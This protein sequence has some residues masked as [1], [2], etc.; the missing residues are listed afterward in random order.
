MRIQHL[1][2]AVALVSLT[3]SCASLSTLPQPTKPTSWLYNS[4]TFEIAPVNSA[5]PSPE[6]LEFFRKRLH[7]N[8]LCHR[9]RVNF[10]IRRYTQGLP[11]GFPWS[12]GSLLTYEQ[13]RR[14]IHDDSP[15][16]SDL[17]VFV[18]YI[19]GLFRQGRELRH[20]G[21]LQYSHTAFAIFKSGARD[22]EG[23]VLL[24]EFGH[25]IGLVKDEDAP[26]HDG[27]NSHHCAIQTCAMY[28]SSPMDKADFD[29]Y[30]KRA[31]R[32]MIRTRHEEKL[33]AQ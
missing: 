6:A 31:I 5:N 25:L 2:L 16:D 26:N 22:R 33:D 27:I 9:D 30:C 4:I 8:R 29:L 20:L 17:K 15:Y 3:I 32:V 23:A 7:E 13:M 21:G 28:H 12:T 24:H 11:K 18:A 10:V 1:A 19:D 14:S